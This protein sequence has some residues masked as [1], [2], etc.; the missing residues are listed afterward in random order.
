MQL[1]I[2]EF[3]KYFFFFFKTYNF[4]NN[5]AKSIF[6]KTVFKST[7]VTEEISLLKKSIRFLFLY[8]L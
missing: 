4:E 6:M 2:F 8:I 5:F 7:S 3:F 1:K